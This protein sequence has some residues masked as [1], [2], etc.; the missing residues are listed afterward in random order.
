MSSPNMNSEYEEIFADKP[1]DWPA[2]S[3]EQTLDLISDWVGKFRETPTHRTREI[4]LSLIN[5]HDLNQHSELGVHRVTEYEVGI[6]N[7]LYVA[8]TFY[9]INSLKTYLYSIISYVTKLQKMVSWCMPDGKGK[10]SLRILPY[11]QGLIPPMKLYHLAYQK[12]DVEKRKT[13]VEQLIEIIE[14]AIC[15]SQGTSEIN[16]ITYAYSSMLL[17]LSNMHGSKTEKIWEFTRGELYRLL[18]LEA[19]LLKKNQQSASERPTKGVLMMQ[20]SNFILKSRNGYNDDYICKYLTPSAAKSSVV[21]QQIWMKR[22]E[23]LNDEREQKV[24]PELFADTSWIKYGWIKDIDF[25]PTRKYYVS[26]FSKALGDTDM[27]NGY[28]ECLYGYKNDI[29]AD[30]IAPIGMHKL[31]KRQG[32]NNDLPEKIKAPYIS[33][34]ITF[35]VLYDED[36]AKEEL[37][38]LF[39]IIDMFDL[40][41]VDKRDFLQAVLQYWIL[42]VK[43]HKWSNERERRYVLFLYD[44]YEYKET[45]FDDVFLKVKTSLFIT[46]DFILGENPSRCEIQKQLEAKRKALYTKEYL[47]CEDCLMQ[48]YDAA[49]LKKPERCPICG[50]SRIKIVSAD[51]QRE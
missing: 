23:L 50:S 34:V 6:I 45:E 51:N 41:D 25:T 5:E 9:Q 38:Y 27:Q 16:L 35:D 20:I 32:V 47:F 2:N 30:L 46:P 40:T 10:N 37:V 28:G 33:Q 22:T 4:L 1:K 13:F 14:S 42:S 31:A 39:S 43:D 36:E 18:E 26:C 17:D 15:L 48:D 24:I 12:F 19:K 3:R 8:A 21:N 11:E 49:I 29:I 7:S 44:D